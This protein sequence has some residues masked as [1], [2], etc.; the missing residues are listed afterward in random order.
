M[1]SCLTRILKLGLSLYSTRTALTSGRSSLIS[2]AT[3]M[4]GHS[5]TIFGNVASY[6][7]C[8]ETSIVRKRGTA[9]SLTGRAETVWPIIITTVII[10]IFEGVFSPYLEEVG[11]ILLRKRHKFRIMSDELEM[12]IEILPSGNYV[13]WQVKPRNRNCKCLNQTMLGN[14]IKF[15]RSNFV[16]FATEKLEHLQ[17]MPHSEETYLLTPCLPNVLVRGTSGRMQ[18]RFCRWSGWRIQSSQKLLKWFVS[19]NNRKCPDSKQSSHNFII[20]SLVVCTL[21]KNF[22]NYNFLINGRYHQEHLRTT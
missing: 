3:C 21:H 19:K 14:Y 17:A 11:E 12:L 8:N 16:Y 7:F 13:A 18:A 5:Y 4:T 9:G 22:V 20:L 1:P 15:L 10:N 2:S 6:W